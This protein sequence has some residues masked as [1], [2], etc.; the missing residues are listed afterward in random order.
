MY[1]IAIYQKHFD[2]CGKTE[3]L[4]IPVLTFFKQENRCNEMISVRKSYISKSAKKQK[5]IAC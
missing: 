5:T 2:L 1:Q 4:K 3:I